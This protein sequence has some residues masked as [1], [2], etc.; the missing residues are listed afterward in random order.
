[1]GWFSPSSKIVK[2]SDN[3]VVRKHYKAGAIFSHKKTVT[4]YKKDWLGRSVSV[5]RRA[6]FWD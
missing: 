1:M 5:Q 3:K 4:V 2:K 6:G